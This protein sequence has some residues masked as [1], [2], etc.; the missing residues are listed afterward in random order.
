MDILIW[1]PSVMFAV[2]G[3][4]PDLLLHHYTPLPLHAWIRSVMISKV[5]L[6]YS[7]AYRRI[8][9]HQNKHREFN[10]FL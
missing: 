2:R 1:M 3:I 6:G 9:S 7:K 10:Q 8:T 4:G 5:L